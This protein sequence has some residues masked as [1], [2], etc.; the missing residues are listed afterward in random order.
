MDGKDYRTLKYDGKSCLI[1]GSEGHGLKQI[2]ESNCD[3]I[4]SI[5][6]KGKINSL[7]ASVSAGILIYEMMKY[8]D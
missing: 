2:V 4:I 3:E 1:I 7:N 6:M 8:K 5:P